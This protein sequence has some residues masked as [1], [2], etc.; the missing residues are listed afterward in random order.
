MNW[1]IALLMTPSV[2]PALIAPLG[3]GG[4]NAQLIEITRYVVE[5]TSSISSAGP[6]NA[7]VITTITTVVTE[8]SAATTTIIAGTIAAK[9]TTVVVTVTTTSAN[10]RHHYYSQ[11]LPPLAPPLLQSELQVTRKVRGITVL[12]TSANGR[13]LLRLRRKN[14]RYCGWRGLCYGICFVSSFALLCPLYGRR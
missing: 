2:G 6:T 7:R 11:P 13:S 9:V 1:V 14:K 8:T 3:I 10:G 5:K 12:P 4:A